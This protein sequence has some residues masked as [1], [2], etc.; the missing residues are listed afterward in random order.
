MQYGAVKALSGVTI[1]APSSTIVGI[2]GANG[3]GK[4]TLFKCI[5]GEQRLASGYVFLDDILVSAMSPTRIG[6]SGISGSSQTP[7]LSEELTIEENLSVARYAP[8]AWR[9]GHLKRSQSRQRVADALEVFGLRAVAKE[10]TS[11]APY[12][13]KKIADVAR[14]FAR[15]SRLVLL[16]EPCAGVDEKRKEALVTGIQHFCALDRSTVMLIEH[17][18]AFIARLAEEIHA[19]DSGTLV[20][21]GSYAKV[22]GDKRVR[23]AFLGWNAES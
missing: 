7:L 17:D 12:A 8:G 5:R 18:L 11:E 22:T 21:S 6:R 15:K 2:I 23:A 9:R 14:A 16:D 3:A 13:I 4:T 1:H 20:A 19:L 10:F